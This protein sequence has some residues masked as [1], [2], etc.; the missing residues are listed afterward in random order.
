MFDASRP[1][2]TGFT[3]PAARTISGFEYDDAGAEG[4]AMPATEAILRLGLFGNVTEE[5]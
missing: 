4:A 1:T 5:G 3:T 2:V